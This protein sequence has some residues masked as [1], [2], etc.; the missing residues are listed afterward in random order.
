MDKVSKEMRSRIMS[1]IRSKDTKMEIAFRKALFKKGVRFRKHVSGLI[2][3]PDI[4]VKSKRVAIFLDSCF[5]H[6]CPR[7]FRK[8]TS[9][10]R[11]WNNKIARNIERDEEINKHYNSAGWKVIRFWE[12]DT[13]R[14][15]TRAVKKAYRVLR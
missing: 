11:Y 2:G 6:R 15:L 4:A 13:E 8:P 3:K 1:A 12:H 10:K 7:H 14:N 9:N 5:W